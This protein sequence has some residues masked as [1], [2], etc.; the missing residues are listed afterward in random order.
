MSKAFT[1]EDDLAESAPLRPL[2][3]L[4]PGAKNYITASGA[5]ALRVELAEL[6]K[7]RSALAT[8]DRG[9]SSSLDQRIARLEQI[10]SS[11]TV[12]EPTPAD[13]VRFGASVAVKYPSGDVEIFKI[14]GIYEIDLD[15][16]YI[17]WQSPL[18]KALTNAKVGDVVRFRAPAGEQRLEILSIEFK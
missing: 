12:V 13:E 11:L 14:V 17:S 7:Q 5:E 1:R 2:P 18:A 8:K 15:R 6:E 3:T 10:L 4:P 9:Q 16:N